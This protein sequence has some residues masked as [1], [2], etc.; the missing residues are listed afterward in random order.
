[1]FLSRLDPRL[2]T[3]I[4]LVA[5]VLIGVSVLNSRH[6]PSGAG[7]GLVVTACF[8]ACVAAWLAWTG[9]PTTDHLTPD[10]YILAVAGGFPPGAA[11]DSPASAFVFVAAATAGVR[12]EL[13]RAFAVVGLGVL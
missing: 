11:P 10:S 3:A 8:V 9:R 12:V 1:M 13:P 5:L 6:P 7:R 2:A 4:R